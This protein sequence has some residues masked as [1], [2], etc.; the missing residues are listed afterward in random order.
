MKKICLQGGHLNRTGGVYGAPMEVE[1][2]KRI[3]DRLSAMLRER[4]FEVKQTDY[5]AYNDPT[6]T[7]VDYDL[8]LSLHC[9]MDYP[10]DNG[11]GFCD[12]PDADLDGNNL[13]SKRICTIINDVYFKETKITYKSRSNP[14]T[15]RYYMWKYLTPRTPCNLIEMGQSI[16]PHDSVLL[17][18]TELIASALTR[19]ICKAFDVAYDL[20]VIPIPKPEPTPEPTVDYEKEYKFQLEVIDGLKKTVDELK[21]SLGVTLANKDTECQQKIDTFSDS[22]K[23]YLINCI[24]EYK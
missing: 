4:G 13:E 14:N 9:D 1:R 21:S 12:F 18:N 3:T 24:K 2:N 11:S 15:K 5:Y 7:K 22:L 17:G 6:V 23:N 10:N 16:D 19:A 20:P 8:F